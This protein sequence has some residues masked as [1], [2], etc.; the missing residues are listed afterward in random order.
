MAYRPATPVRLSE[1][2]GA[3]GV[4]ILLAVSLGLLGAQSVSGSA[5]D[6]AGS[7]GAVAASRS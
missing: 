2:R 6:K 4:V 5:G 7:I 3:I 1:R